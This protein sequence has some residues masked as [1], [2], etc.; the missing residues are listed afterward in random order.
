[1]CFFQAKKQRDD[2]KTP[3][4]VEM[5]VPLAMRGNAKDGYNAPSSAIA[6]AAIIEVEV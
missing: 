5:A 6:S 2:T 1:M 4:E 3:N